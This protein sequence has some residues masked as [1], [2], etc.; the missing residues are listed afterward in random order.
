MTRVVSES[1]GDS[2]M[3]QVGEVLGDVSA[4]DEALG[5]TE[6]LENGRTQRC[7]QLRADL[8]VLRG[9][10]TS[11]REAILLQNEEL[12]G[13]RVVCA[14]SAAKLAHIG[15]RLG[16]LMVQL[17]GTLECQSSPIHAYI[18]GASNIVGSPLSIGEREAEPPSQISY[19]DLVSRMRRLEL[20][21]VQHSHVEVGW[22]EILSW[23]SVEWAMEIM[24]DPGIVS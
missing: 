23:Y 20:H 12:E 4:F 10:A 18:D 13:M 2:S 5:D 6:V 1:S 14:V 22:R 17:E 19:V 3:R 8:L 24:V 16:S 11:V 21:R 15:E 9:K 7:H